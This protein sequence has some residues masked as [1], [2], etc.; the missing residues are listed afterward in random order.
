MLRIR[1]HSAILLRVCGSFLAFTVFCNP[2]FSQTPSTSSPVASSSASSAITGQPSERIHGSL[3]AEIPI[4]GSPS[5]IIRQDPAALAELTAHLN[6]VGQKPWVGFQAI[7]TISY[8]ATGA[9]PVPVT[10]YIFPKNEFRMDVALAKGIWSTRIFEYE[11]GE[12]PP[13]SKAYFLPSETAAVGF[14][15]FQ[16]LRTAGFPDA[17]TS[18]IDKGMVP[19]NGS[20]LHGITTAFATTHSGI[21]PK[22]FI[23]LD[24]YFDP[25]THLL[26]KSSTRIKLP[27]SGDASLHEV[28]TYSNYQN[29]NGTQLPFGFRETIDGDF[30]WEIT[31]T[32]VNLVSAPPSA[33]FTF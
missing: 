30:R 24:L 28:M 3:D 25:H 32:Q 12:M 21:L 8:S 6:A 22:V 11:G 18:F 1:V 17:T 4:P 13:N 10:I 20:L 33:F 29:V 9:N 19:V 7:G 16:H 5:T 23:P 31:L 27:S 14:I 2:L 15:H 26:I